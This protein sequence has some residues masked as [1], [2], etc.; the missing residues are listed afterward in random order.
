MV[1]TFLKRPRI[2][3]KGKLI[4]NIY[5]CIFQVLNIKSKIMNIEITV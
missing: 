1:K 5:L 2:S 4:A 3:N